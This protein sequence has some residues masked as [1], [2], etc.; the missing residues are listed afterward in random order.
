MLDVHAPHH[1]L[2]SVREFVVHILTITVGLLIALGLEAS[3]EHMHHRHQRREAE[4]TIR[5]EIQQ[6][7]DD[8]VKAQAGIKVELKGMVDVLDFLEARSNGQPGDPQG[9]NLNFREG[10]LQDSAWRTAASTGVLSYME[11]ADVQKYA[12][13]YKEQ[14]LF[15]AMQQ[16]TLDEYLQLDSYVV[17]GFDPKTLSADNVKAALP[18]VRRALAHLGGML[19]VSRGALMAYDDALKQ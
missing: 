16:Q 15:E 18:D 6:N 5:R 7:R 8:L 4:A 13:A 2:D 10:P 19:D 11:Y 12:L 14:D 17:K 3:V 1:K 9:L